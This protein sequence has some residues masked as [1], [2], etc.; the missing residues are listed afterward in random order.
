MDPGEG[1]V[2]FMMTNDDSRKQYCKIDG[3]LHGALAD[4]KKKSDL[5]ILDTDGI[6]G[7]ETAYMAIKETEALVGGYSPL[8]GSIPGLSA[9]H[10]AVAAL[11]I[12]NQEIYAPPVQDNPYGVNLCTSEKEMDIRSI[13]C[14]KYNCLRERGYIRLTR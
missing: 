10:C 3:V 13:A 6:A 9:F 11:I 12:K 2:F 14:V 8:F 7:D 5:Y 4:D 1:A